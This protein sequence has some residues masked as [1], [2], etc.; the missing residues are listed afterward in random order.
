MGLHNVLKIYHHRNII[1]IIAEN[2]S[3]S[4]KLNSLEYLF[5]LCLTM[6]LVNGAE[7][8]CPRCPPP[9]EMLV[10]EISN[11]KQ[12]WAHGWRRGKKCLRGGERFSCSSHIP[13]LPNIVQHYFKIQT[14][15]SWLCMWSLWQPVAA[16]CLWKSKLHIKIFS[17][18]F[19]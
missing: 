3:N 1:I 7:P 12:L 18:T 15:R 14:S 13:C 5:T 8:Y 10:A 6:Y 2:C 11:S 19:P 17:S 4:G 16:W 9:T